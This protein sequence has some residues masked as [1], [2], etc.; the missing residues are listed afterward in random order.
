MTK[1]GVKL[2]TSE[3]KKQGGGE[4]SKME[5]RIE[6]KKKIEAAGTGK[7]PHNQS[8]AKSTHFFNLGPKTSTG[9]S[10]RWRTKNT[11][12]GIFYKKRS[13]GRP[14][15]IGKV[16]KLERRDARVHIGLEIELAYFLRILLF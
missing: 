8:A 2:K 13:T 11:I 15:R 1:I 10:R 6:E 4:Q 5:V 7:G 9:P 3:D 12:A 14:E 16:E